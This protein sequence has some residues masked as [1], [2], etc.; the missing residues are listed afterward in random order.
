MNLKNEIINLLAAHQVT[1]ADAYT[2]LDE[3]KEI[4]KEQLKV[5]EVKM[6]DDELPFNK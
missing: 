2:L 5:A 6:L 3:C 4:L 1:I